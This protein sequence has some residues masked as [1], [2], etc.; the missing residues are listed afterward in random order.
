M[1]SGNVK[2]T[3]FHQTEFGRILGSA[4]MLVN[5]QTKIRHVIK[6]CICIPVILCKM[7]I[8]VMSQKCIGIGHLLMVMMMMLMKIMKYKQNLPWLHTLSL[9]Q[10]EDTLIAI[11]DYLRSTHHYCVWCS[12]TFTG[13]SL[14]S[15][16]ALISY[17]SSHQMKMI[18]IIIVLVIQ[19]KIIMTNI[20][21][22]QHGWCLRC[23]SQASYDARM[24]IK[25]E[26][27][28][29]ITQH[30]VIFFKYIYFSVVLSVKIKSF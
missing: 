19:L 24:Y 9:F 10:P 14:V 21:P 17:F 25:I 20:Y 23:M 8:R 13:L 22:L 7:D 11:N 28:L 30:H 1:I 29:Y 12:I 26:L 15:L 4:N 6:H 27:I 16:N 2:R 3:S 5:N 18:C